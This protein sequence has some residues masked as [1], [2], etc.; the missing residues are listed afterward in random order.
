[1]RAAENFQALQEELAATE[2]KIAVSRQIYNDTTLTYNNSV[3]TIPSN[4]VAAATGFKTRPY[5]EAEDEARTVPKAE[6]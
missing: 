1:M 6:F 4:L 3:Q 2:G 5:L